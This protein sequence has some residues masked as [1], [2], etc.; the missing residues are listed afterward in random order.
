MNDKEKTK[1]E[2]AAE[3]IIANKELTFQN[4][5]KDKRIAELVIANKEMEAFSYLA[6]HDLGAFWAVI[7]ELPTDGR[8]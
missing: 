8:L 3:L 1:E 5:E 4:E 7:N 6:S 2:W